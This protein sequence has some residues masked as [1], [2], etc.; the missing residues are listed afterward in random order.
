METLVYMRIWHTHFP[1]DILLDGAGSMQHD[2]KCKVEATIIYLDKSVHC[3]SWQNN[4][5]FFFRE[6]ASRPA[7][8]ES[9]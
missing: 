4:C 3:N 8:I 1:L 2:P 5:F 6:E 9:E 7:F